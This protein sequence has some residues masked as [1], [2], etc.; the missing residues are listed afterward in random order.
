MGRIIQSIILLFFLTFV[1]F[2]QAYSLFNSSQPSFVKRIKILI[3]ACD[4]AVADNNALELEKFSDLLIRE[5]ES[6]KVDSALLAGFYYK[7]VY[8]Q[9]K[10]KWYL[11]SQNF[12]IASKYLTASSNPYRTSLLYRSLIDVNN[13]YG[14]YS[15]SL[16]YCNLLY[17]EV[18][19]LPKSI[20][21]SS[22]IAVQLAFSEIYLKNHQMD[23]FKSKIGTLGYLCNNVKNDKMQWQG[24]QC[25]LEYYKDPLVNKVDSV[26]KILKVMQN[27]IVSSHNISEKEQLIVYL[28]SAQVSMVLNDFVKA[29]AYFEKIEHSGLNYIFPTEYH[30][31]KGKYFFKSGKYQQAIH[32]FKVSANHSSSKLDQIELEVNQLIKQSYDKLNLSDSAQLYALK[33]AQLE[34]LVAANEIK[35]KQ[36]L[37]IELTNIIEQN[38]RFQDAEVSDK[39]STLFILT[40]LTIIVVLVVMFVRLYRKNKLYIIKEFIMHPGAILK[41]SMK[42]YY[43]IKLVEDEIKKINELLQDLQFN[44]LKHNQNINTLKLQNYSTAHLNSDYEKIQSSKK[45]PTPSQQMILERIKKVRIINEE[46]WMEFQ[47]LFVQIYPDYYNFLHENFYRY[48]TEGEFR[49]ILLLKLNFSNKEI[50]LCLGIT[51]ETS[52]VAIYRLRKK[53]SAKGLE[54]LDEI[55][56]KG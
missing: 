28:E 23:S 5:G 21:N 55:L 34:K 25:W 2:S 11:A 18:N 7:G 41:L 17:S 39:W 1:S 51:M 32:H 35:E 29:N 47:Q 33:I 8:Y 4:S 10:G 45:S 26:V 19:R 20:K 37:A 22:L 52:R 50:S 24:L 38:V 49:M 6:Q 44:A 12:T 15:Q 36:N 14:L 9:S 56:S 13:Y 30:V 27:L 42:N 40:V 53:L 43:R 31:S 16:K 48:L 54:S 46:N 3:R